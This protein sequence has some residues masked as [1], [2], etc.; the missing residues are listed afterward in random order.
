MEKRKAMT[1]TFEQAAVMAHGE[2]VP[3]LR[4]EHNKGVWLRFSGPARVPG[5]WKED[6][7]HHR[8]VR[9]AEGNWT[10]VGDETR[11]GSKDA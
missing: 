8:L 4:N 10:T 6:R 3:T 9:R 5:L 11:H 2:V 1:P 7:R